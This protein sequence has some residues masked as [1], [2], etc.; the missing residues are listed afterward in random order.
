M[1]W[2]VKWMKSSIC[3]SSSIHDDCRRK[4]TVK[5]GRVCKSVIKAKQMATLKNQRMKTY[6]A[7]YIL[8]HVLLCNFH[9]FLIVLQQKNKD[10]ASTR[11]CVETFCVHPQ[12]TGFNSWH[13]LTHLTHSEKENTLVSIWVRA[14]Q[15]IKF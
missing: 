7:H 3:K 5:M 1:S 12:L 10:S 4:P 11:R 2:I 13:T 8:P 6:L 15:L 9:V 14:A